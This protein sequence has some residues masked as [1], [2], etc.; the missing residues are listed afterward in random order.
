[1]LKFVNIPQ[2][3]PAKRDVAEPDG[4]EP[5]TG[6][7]D[8]ERIARQG[9]R[10]CAAAPHAKQPA[11]ARLNDPPDLEDACAALP[12]PNEGAMVLRGRRKATKLLFVVSARRREDE[13]LQPF[14][15]ARVEGQSTGIAEENSEAYGPRLFLKQGCLVRDGDQLLERRLIGKIPRA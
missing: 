3:L 12:H 2:R 9:R 7:A 1:M 6:D 15:R 14:G 10:E 13:R 4:H 5:R 11:R 8:D